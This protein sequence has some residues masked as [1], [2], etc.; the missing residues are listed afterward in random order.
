MVNVIT[1]ISLALLF[2]LASCSPTSA[3]VPQAPMPTIATQPSVSPATPS[4]NST[5]INPTDVAWEKVIEAAKKEG[6]VTVYSYQLVGDVGLTVARAFKEQ[7]GI[8]MDII[9]GRGAEF[10]ERLKVE[11]RMGQVVAD[12]GDGSMLHLLNMKKAG[13]TLG[14]AERAP[15]FGEQGVW[16]TNVFGYDATD[17]HVAALSFYYLSP[18]INSKLVK[19]GEEPQ[20]WRDLL[21]PQWKGQIMVSDPAVSGN[22]PQLFV[23]LL[24]EKVIDEQFLKDLY[25]QDLAFT[26]SLY[27]EARL[28]G[29]GERLISIYGSPVSYSRFLAEGAPIKAIDLKDGVTSNLNPGVVIFG[30]GPHPNAARVY[31]NWMFSP[32]GQ[33][34]FS[35]AASSRPVRKDVPDPSPEASRINPQRPLIQTAEDTD[36]AAQLFTEKWLN[37][38]WGRS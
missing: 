37:K 17:K 33:S 1:A 35:K 22:A 20:V 6:T 32:G 10:V 30:G 11:K 13:L 26:V 27:D 21:K 38:L 24:R 23:P 34:A 31:A 28:L 5:A 7:Y 15:V 8:K 16:E 9:T 2:L 12:V 36:K 18:W 4:T 25:K 19:P 29:R 3:P 14:L